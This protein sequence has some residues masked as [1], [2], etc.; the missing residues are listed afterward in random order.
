MGESNQK[1]PSKG[2][3]LRETGFQCGEVVGERMVDIAS[4]VYSK[5]SFCV[6]ELMDYR[7]MC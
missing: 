5:L 6:K 1:L 3:V 4:C 2:I 7:R